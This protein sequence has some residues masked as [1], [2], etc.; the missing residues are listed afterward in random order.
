MGAWIG[1]RPGRCS[2]ATRCSLTTPSSTAVCTSRR[3]SPPGWRPSRV[4]TRTLLK[5]VEKLEAERLS[6]RPDIPADRAQFARSL[7]LDPDPWQEQLLRSEAPRGM[8]NCCRQS[9]KST[10]AAVIAL[11]RALTVPRSLVLCLAPA[12]RQSQELFGK[13][14]GFLS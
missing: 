14:L 5:E 1:T 8:L 4:N 2:P 7:S 9:G 12:L 10:M 13:V 11:H 3:S 6:G